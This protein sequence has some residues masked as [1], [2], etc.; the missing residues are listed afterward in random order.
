[1]ADYNTHT[2]FG[3][4]VLEQ[5][6][7][8][9]RR[10]FTQDLP[11]FRLGLNG[12]DPLIFL[13]WT[14]PE[15]CRFHQVWRQEGLPRFVRA[16][17]GENP[18]QA[19]FAAG[20]TLHLMLDDVV[21]PWIKGWIQEGSSH[22]RLELGLDR[23]IVQEQG[24]DRLPRLMTQ[25]RERTAQ[26]AAELLPNTQADQFLWG[27]RNMMVSVAYL[28]RWGEKHEKRITEE[29]HSQI[30]FLRMS[31]EEAVRPTADYLMALLSK[32]PAKA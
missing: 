26:A 11:A 13:P 27:L 22:F 21:H 2:Y 5:L 25:G 28:R 24:L 29:E 32:E 19:S 30:R 6:P 10:Q 14:K 3:M 17:E 23:L 16:M 18:T 4:R 1:M 8:D 20:C 9:L 12:P 7:L 15:A 31:L